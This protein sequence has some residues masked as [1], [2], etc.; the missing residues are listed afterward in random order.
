MVSFYNVFIACNETA[1]LH[2]VIGKGGLRIFPKCIPVR[3]CC[4]LS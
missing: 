1:S 4:A 3:L 2:D